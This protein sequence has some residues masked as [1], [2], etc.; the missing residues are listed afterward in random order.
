M[1]PGNCDPSTFPAVQV[2]DWV[3]GPRVQGRV[4]EVRAF[5]ACVDGLSFSLS[6]VKTVRRPSAEYLKIVGQIRRDTTA[7]GMLP[8]GELNEVTDG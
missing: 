8:S 4:R 6:E 1:R 2:D 3:E 7:P 5:S